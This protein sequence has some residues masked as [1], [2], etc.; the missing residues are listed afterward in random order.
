MTDKTDKTTHQGVSGKGENRTKNAVGQ[1]YQLPDGNIV[2][3]EATE[4]LIRLDSDKPLSANEEKA[5]QEWLARGPVH[6]EA[7]NQLNSFWGNQ[8][9]TELITS[10]AGARQAGQNQTGLISALAA[11]FKAYL[12]TM[13][14]LAVTASLVAVTLTLGLLIGSKEI[15]DSNGLYVT[16]V[17]QQKTIEMADGSRLQLN[18]NSQVEVDYNQS[19]RNIRLIQGEVHFEVAKNPQLPFRVYAGSGRVQAVGTA[20]TV[21]LKDKDVDVLVTEGR[22]AL[23][24]LTLAEQENPVGKTKEKLNKVDVN[25]D[26]QIDTYANSLP[27]ELAELDAGQGVILTSAPQPGEANTTAQLIAQTISDEEFKRRQSW[28]SGLL[29]FSGEPLEQVISEVSRYTT[30]TI[31]I[32]DPAL[33]QVEI[34]GRFRVGN[35]DEMFKA[36][37]A[38]FGVKVK[39]LAYNHV[40]LAS[41]RQ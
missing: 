24:S 21:Y 36:L 39:R 31:D 37:E 13:R 14:G 2:D 22:V 12:S 19:Y 32:A 3:Q 10:S 8:V 16:A 20:F 41:A 4:W 38:N 34:G 29:V 40:Q 9:L 35:M 15:T 27:R 5:F 17:G 33:G 1:L 28:R 6:R 30:I 25:P 7:I 11:N 18:T 23:A 26:R